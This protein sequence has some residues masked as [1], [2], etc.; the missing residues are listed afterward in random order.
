M[1]KAKIIIKR[2]GQIARGKNNTTF[3]GWAFGTT[4]SGV[5]SFYVDMDDDGKFFVDE[6]EKIS[7]RCFFWKEIKMSKNGLCDNRL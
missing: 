6:L 2:I 4:G 1:F 3:I 5:I 7:H